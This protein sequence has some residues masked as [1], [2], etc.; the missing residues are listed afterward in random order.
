MNPRQKVHLLLIISELILCLS[1]L[2]LSI[3]GCVKNPSGK[4][5]VWFCSKILTVNNMIKENMDDTF[6]LTEIESDDVNS[7]FSHNYYDLLHH[8]TKN[9]CEP[10]YKKCG[11]LDTL[12]NIMCI[13]EQDNCP[14]NKIVLYSNYG[15]LNFSYLN[16][17]LFYTNLA[18][19]DD[20]VSKLVL[21]DKQ[22]RYIT[23]DNFIFDEDSYWKIFPPSHGGGD[24]DYDYYDSD[25]GSYDSGDSGGGGDWGGVGGGDGDWRILEGIYG[26]DNKITK[27]INKKMEE[28]NNIDNNFKSITYNLYSRNYIGFETYDQMEQFVNF[29]FTNMYLVIFPNTA[30]IVFGYLGIIPF[31]IIIIFSISRFFYKDKP[32][33]TTDSFC[34]YCT[35]VMVIIIYMSFFLGYFFFFI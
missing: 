16:F 7:T 2:T 13:P 3:I 20:I 14:I 5:K 12:G 15:Y 6:A 23:E 28:D 34:K 27:Y 18:T 21:S 26:E 32:N 19:N 1:I 24:S 22:P 9:E 35:K 33:Q 25:S 17:D 30:S 11:I 8:S 4:E 29:D 31:L 10:N